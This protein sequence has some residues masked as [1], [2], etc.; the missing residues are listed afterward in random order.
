LLTDPV[1]KRGPFSLF[2]GRSYATGRFQGREVALR[3]Q[4]KRSRYGQGYLVV[5]TSTDGLPD[6]DYDGIEAR[7]RD[8]AGRRALYAIATHDLVLGLEKGW[9][10]ALWKPQ[11]FTIFPGHF[12]EK[13]W[14]EVLEA[15]QVLATSLERA[16][17]PVRLEDS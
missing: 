14:R 5:A 12:S 13:K 3:L 8:E 16:A 7:A 9:L 15:M 11:G 1:I 10:R 6:L 2:S 17:E 4:L